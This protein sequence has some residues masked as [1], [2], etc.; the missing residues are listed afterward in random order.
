MVWE[1]ETGGKLTKDNWLKIFSKAYA[2]AFTMSTV[3]SAFS[4]T[5]VWPLN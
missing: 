5:G 1:R 4:K 2:A 3:K